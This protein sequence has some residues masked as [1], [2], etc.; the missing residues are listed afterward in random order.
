MRDLSIKDEWNIIGDIIFSDNEIFEMI[1]N[2]LEKPPINVT[3]FKK[4]EFKLKEVYQ[5][6]L[7]LAYFVFITENTIKRDTTINYSICP[8]TNKIF[9]LCHCIL[10][11]NRRVFPPKNTIVQVMAP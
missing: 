1:L 8:N 11:E 2:F 9:R 6:G 7:N 4:L 5:L 3:D 10:C